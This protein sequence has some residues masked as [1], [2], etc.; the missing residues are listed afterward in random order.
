M[1]III[2][3][4][5]AVINPMTLLLIIIGT[6]FG[7]ICGSL[8][9][10]STSMAIILCLPFTYSMD[11]IAAIVLL[12]AV[13][14]GGATGGSISA[15]LLKTPGTPESVATTFDGYPMAQKGMA[16]QA[17]GLAV[18]ASAFGAIFSA[19]IMLLAAP[20]LAAAALS[21]QS[22]EYFGLG[23]IGLGCIT[24]IG[25]RNQMKAILS[26]L[27][28]LMISTIGL[29]S[30]N[31]VERF[32]FGQPFLLN[33][34]NY[35]SV[36]I[37]AFAIAEV[38]KNIE[39]YYHRDTSLRTDNKISMKLMKFSEMTKMWDTFVKGSILGTII[40][41]IPAA[42]GSIASLIAYGEASGRHKDEKP[43]F[44]E[45]NPRGIIAPESSNNAAV[46]G[47]MVPT[48][49]L[50]I[51]GSPVAAVI[52]AAFL[53]IGLSPGPLL[54]REQPIML[55]VIFLAMIASALLLFICGRFVISQFAH[56]LKLPYPLL[57]TLIVAL[58]LVGAYSLKNSF[59]DVLIMF[60]FGLV[61]YFFD[62]F[63]YSSAALILGL[64]LGDLIENSL[65]RQIII[66]DG[67]AMGFVTRP[68]A[69]VIIVVA[70]LAFIWPMISKKLKK[71]KVAA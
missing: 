2:Q 50:G 4:L 24:S 13:Y 36:M 68:L 10:L 57:G 71:N 49:V 6:L 17:L 66:G 53:I 65:R 30:I 25:A 46:G 16:G 37:G 29:D 18:T 14:L 8:P 58:G 48:M 39:K 12:V 41:I 60:I 3:S 51:P 35:I 32:A 34:I 63:K 5:D 70:I 38:Y 27:L 31:G 45:G 54:I 62:K 33:G 21:F 59:Y 69:L 26:V 23:L 40:G 20:L 64:I 43:A 22:A 11:P 56:I 52:M 61:G 7:V 55:N 15:I 47:S 9:G 19:F 28:G 44:G 1:D 67:S 42:G